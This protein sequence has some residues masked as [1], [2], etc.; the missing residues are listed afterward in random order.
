MAADYLFSVVVP[1]YKVEKY[2]RETLESVVNQTIGFRE[3][4]QLILI[5]DGSPDRSEEICLA[6]QKRFPENIRYVCTENGGVSRARN[7]GLE[8][9][10]GEYI[11]FLD[12]DDKWEIHAFERAAAFFEQH[13]E[14]VDVLAARI[15][16]FDNGT[17]Y[18]P[19]DYKFRRG[20]RIVD[21]DDRAELYSFQTTTATTF[22]RRSCIGE[23]RF[24]PRLKYGEDATFINKLILKRKAYGLDP[25]IL[26]CYRKRREANSA[27]NEQRFD[28][29]YYIESLL[30]YHQELARYSRALFG[31]VLPNIQ[32]LVGYD[33]GRRIG[34]YSYFSVLSA[35]D[36]ETY[37][38]Q[39][40][41]ILSWIEDAIILGSPTHTDLRRKTETMRLKNEALLAERIG[42][43]ARSGHVPD[44]AEKTWPGGVPFFAGNIDFFEPKGE[45]LRMEGR[46]PTWAF[47]LCAVE[48]RLVFRTE[49][50]E[51][52][53]EL[54]IFRPASF[55]VGEEMRDEFYRFCCSLPLPRTGSLSI[56][57]E[58]RYAGAA[59]PLGFSATQFVAAS[60]AYP[61][62][63]R[64][65]G[66][67][68]LRVFQDR[69]SCEKHRFPAL[70]QLKY[71]LR[72]WKYSL[73][74]GRKYLIKIR[75]LYFLNRLCKGKKQLWLFSDRMDNAGD[76]GEVFFRYVC[77][78]CPRN[79][80]PVFVIGKNAGCVPRL[81]GEG[82]VLFFNTRAYRYAFLLADKIISSGASE[83]TVNAWGTNRQ[84]LI[85]LYR[86]RYYYLQHGV[87]CAD[88]T[89]WLNKV[90]K[91][92]S[93]IF[94]SANK[95]TQAFREGAYYYEPEQIRL[96]GMA[97]FDALRN[98]DS[99]QILIMPTW[100]KSIKESYDSATNSVYFEGFRETEYFKFYNTLIN[101]EHLLAAMR[102]QGYRG[103]FC[104]HPIHQKQYVDFEGNDV[105]RINEGYVDYNQV[106]EDS[107]L[108][109]TDYSSVLFDFA[110]LRKS[111]V[112]TQFD[113]EQF[114]NDQS[115]DQGYFDYEEDG[116]GPVCYDYEST[117]E[118]LV[119]QVESGCVNPERYRER[120]DRFFRY[121]DQH[122][123]ERILQ[124]ILQDDRN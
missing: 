70:A 46:V 72:Y 69:L 38:T 82:K 22:I 13:G 53:A 1:I 65:Y 29:S 43:A 113:K 92:L 15:R 78:H 85:D 101:D 51:A 117:V 64:F 91:N 86:F 48:P 34:D 105:F 102:K 73:Q 95:E 45:A 10:E 32:A 87:A 17:H 52:T 71:E 16:F 24:D 44:N 74:H 42:E 81:Q 11:N 21:L 107:S 60:C 76:N 114:F 68:C 33:M 67:Y 115:Y 79:V 41:E 94:T 50:A 25:E 12:S 123:C 124:S 8:L 58:L 93:V 89:T 57:A 99:K 75:A 20:R 97:R 118:T 62:M 121:A 23:L 106:F 111:V 104:L 66:P 39:R 83:F 77:A 26:Y 36:C 9:A 47:R 49:G 4:I 59:Y 108:M 18:H 56:R 3:H 109:V 103:L 98:G 2:L 100:R 110:Y 120:E 84:Y 119:R 27:V 122:N 7:R 28:R 80:K 96:T 35:A 30:Y 88:L 61:P 19:L 116:F 55:Q 14:R 63:Y 112:Y 5:N 6:Y 37:E 40:R 90:N 54:E 31:E